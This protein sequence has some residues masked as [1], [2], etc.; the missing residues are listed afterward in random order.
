MEP[1]QFFQT[2]RTVYEK[3]VLTENKSYAENQVADDYSGPELEIEVIHRITL[4]D[5]AGHLIELR[6][7]NLDKVYDSGDNDGIGAQVSMPEGTID[8]P[9]SGPSTLITTWYYKNNEKLESDVL[10]KASAMYQHAILE[11]GGL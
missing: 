10:A 6:M 4:T 3:R 5:S 7:D 1:Y 2:F 11:E 9:A 8:I